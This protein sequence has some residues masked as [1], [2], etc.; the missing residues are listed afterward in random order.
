MGRIFLKRIDWIGEW[1]TSDFMRMIGHELKTIK[2]KLKIKKLIEMIGIWEKIVSV[3]PHSI[4]S[5]GIRWISHSPKWWCL[6]VMGIKQEFEN[7]SQQISGRPDHKVLISDWRH[8]IRVEEL[9]V[10]DW[11]KRFG[12]IEWTL[13]VLMENHFWKWSRGLVGKTTIWKM[14]F[15]WFYGEGLL[16]RI[17]YLKPGKRNG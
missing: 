15:W 2:L 12:D 14:L 6:D 11:E 5:W 8:R 17:R 10:R 16:M 3:R 9:F 7:A 1:G 4:M 13:I